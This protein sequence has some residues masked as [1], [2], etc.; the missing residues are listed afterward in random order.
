M[1]ACRK[2]CS[3]CWMGKEKQEGISKQK[4]NKKKSGNRAL[5]WPCRRAQSWYELS[6][7]TGRTVKAE[8]RES[9][10]ALKLSCSLLVPAVS[11]EKKEKKLEIQDT[12]RSR[13]FF[14]DLVQLSTHV[15]R[16]GGG[17]WPFWPAGWGDNL[18]LFAL[19]L[20]RWKK[21]T[22]EEPSS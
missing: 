2:N 22:C 4:K 15:V 6:L 19:I 18:K 17:P 10:T 11:P 20:L 8:R 12:N 1:Y 13:N 16:V 14:S 21:W 9:E 3:A 5:F 7:C